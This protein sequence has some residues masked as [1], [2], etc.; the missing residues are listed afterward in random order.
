MYPGIFCLEYGN[1]QGVT[2][3]GPQRITR[4]TGVDRRVDPLRLSIKPR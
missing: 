1:Y 4:F 2:K 3:K